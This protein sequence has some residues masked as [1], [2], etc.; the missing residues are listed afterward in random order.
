MTLASGLGSQ[1]GLARELVAY[2]TVA[3]PTTFFEFDSEGMGRTPTYIESRGLHAGTMIQNSGRVVPTTHT[4]SG[5]VAM[6]VPS[7]GFG[8][9]LDLLHNNTVTPTQNGATTAYTQTH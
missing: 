9:I 4:A 5:T 2:G 3:T 6:D 1:L 8:T 7:K